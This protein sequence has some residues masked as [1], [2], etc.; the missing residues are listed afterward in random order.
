MRLLAWLGRHAGGAIAVGVFAGLLLPGLAGLAKPFLVPAIL[1][2]FVVALLRVEGAGLRRS[3][4][5][6][7][8]AAAWVLLGAPLLVAMLMRGLGV[9]EPLAAILVVT[10]ACPPIMA[11]SALALLMGL[12]VGLAIVVTVAASA[13][14][15]LTLPPLALG[16][17]GL[18]VALEAEAFLARL[19][20]LVG[21]CFALAALLR[22]GLGPERIAG[23]R[24]ELGGLA[25]LG[26][27]LF[28]VGI[29][30]GVGP[31]LLAE[32]LLVLGW[33]AAASALNLGLQAG[34]A[35]LT[36]RLG[37]RTALTLGLLAGNNNLGLV[38]AAMAGAAPEAFVLFVAVAQFPIYLLPS[39]QRPLYRS[40]LMTH[41][42]DTER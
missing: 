27:I 4:P 7:G 32:P 39:V 9:A 40:W 16:L 37:P 29:M 6:A 22:R 3:L 8:L 30:E 36:W 10:A 2:P 12:D 1:V 38:L 23:R 31:R 35:L 15:P 20:L 14:V 33:L 42:H 24:D 25:V 5:R 28:A 11:S 21:G 26:L 34:T 17:A 41:E 19:A 18:P 13:I